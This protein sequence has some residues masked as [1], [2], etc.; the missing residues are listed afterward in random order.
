MGIQVQ[1]WYDLQKALYDVMQLEKWGASMVLI[2]ISIVAAFNIVGSLTMV[3]I[4]KRRDMGVLQSMGASRRDVRRIFL[5]EGS[6]IG[7]L[8]AGSGFLLAWA[9]RWCSNTLPLYPWLGPNPL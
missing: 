5:L 3:V 8:G 2:L 4:E 7:L 1:T 9:L 6:L